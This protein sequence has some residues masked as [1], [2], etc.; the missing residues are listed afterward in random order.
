MDRTWD[1]LAKK[2]YS[3]TRLTR[4]LEE[5][6][7]NVFKI[8]PSGVEMVSSFVSILADVGVEM[9]FLTNF[10]STA[11]A[12]LQISCV[13]AFYCPIKVPARGRI[14]TMIYITQK[15]TINI[16]IHKCNKQYTNK[17]FAEIRLVH[18]Y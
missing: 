13:F 6:W 15:K 2:V 12:E 4:S 5:S 1:F 18:K 3:E 10:F 17:Q 9:G 7:R 11:C 8:D 14:I 16:L